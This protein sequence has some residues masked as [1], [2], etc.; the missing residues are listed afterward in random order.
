MMPQKPVSKNIYITSMQQ[1]IVK[2][3]LQFFSWYSS[4]FTH[5]YFNFFRIMIWWPLILLSFWS[6]KKR[7][8]Q[9]GSG[10]SARWVRESKTKGGACHH[11]SSWNLFATQNTAP[12]RFFSP[13]RLH[14]HVQIL[15]LVRHVA[16]RPSRSYLFNL[17][18]FVFVCVC[19]L[20][21]WSPRRDLLSGYHFDLCRDAWFGSHHVRLSLQYSYCARVICVYWQAT[22]RRFY[23][24]IG[25][26]NRRYVCVF[27]VP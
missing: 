15:F 11:E 17:S 7:F 9:I 8:P 21:C 4:L 23:K 24:Y 3:K 10:N 2:L 6:P 19:V 16:W 25:F 18:V 20:N 13:F 22:S 26:T 1:I 14:Q 12:L 5:F 27:S